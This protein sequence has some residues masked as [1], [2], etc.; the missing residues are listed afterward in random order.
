MHQETLPT[1]ASLEE[2]QFRFMLTRA[3]NHYSQRLN[4]LSKDNEI[5]VGTFSSLQTDVTDI[6][7]KIDAISEIFWHWQIP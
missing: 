5:N 4:A 6:N 2:E 7:E 3:L 1:L